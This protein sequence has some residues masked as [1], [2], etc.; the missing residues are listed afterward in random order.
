MLAQRRIWLHAVPTVEDWVQEQLMNTGLGALAK[1]SFDS[2]TK[3]GNAFF[4]EAELL[5]DDARFNRLITWTC[6]K[7]EQLC[8]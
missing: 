2:L 5:G 6:Y 4:R 7:V 1:T 8:F 3:F